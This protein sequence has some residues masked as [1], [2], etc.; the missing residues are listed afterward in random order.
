MI[1][2]RKKLQRKR[3]ENEKEQQ[4]KNDLFS[5]YRNIL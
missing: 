5:E 4:R 2:I 3:Q 1:I